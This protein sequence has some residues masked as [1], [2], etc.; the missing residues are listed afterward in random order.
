MRS[1]EH[2]QL[3]RLI[4]P[5]TEVLWSFDKAIKAGG[6]R[7]FFVGEQT[8]TMPE[9][10]LSNMQ[11]AILEDHVSTKAFNDQNLSNMLDFRSSEWLEIIIGDKFCQL[12]IK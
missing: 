7:E 10:V 4:T 6:G 5:Q 11:R 2:T 3:L 12:I 9:S 1:G 8:L